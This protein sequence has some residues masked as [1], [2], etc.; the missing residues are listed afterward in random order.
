MA[1]ALREKEQGGVR[2]AMC[3]NCSKMYPLLDDKGVSNELPS[4]CRRCGS[5]M[6]AAR[7]LVFADEQAAK[8]HQPGLT[9][10][11]D[12][13][14]SRGQVPDPIAGSRGRGKGA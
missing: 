11:A 9:Q 5:P 4:K 8:D 1:T 6:D 13:M 10:L 12:A 14:R 7:A 3:P 2:V